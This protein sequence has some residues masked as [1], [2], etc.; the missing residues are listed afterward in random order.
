VCSPGA[1]ESVNDEVAAMR[2]VH[3]VEIVVHVDNALSQDQRDDLINH[4]VKN[5]GVEMAKFTP[6]HEHLMLVDYDCDKLHA[7]DVL[8]YI[9]KEHAT[10]EMVG[11]I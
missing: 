5:D 10:A 7:A 2:N 8:G 3:Q 9:Q 11:P 4:I 1:V 6:S